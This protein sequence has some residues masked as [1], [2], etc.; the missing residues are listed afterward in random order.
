[1]DI[2]TPIIK[3]LYNEANAQKEAKLAN[4]ANIALEDLKQI[5]EK[6]TINLS[7]PSP[8]SETLNSD[9]KKSTPQ[10]NGTVTNEYLGDKYYDCYKLGCNNSMP[11]KIQQAS[12]D[13][14]QKLSAHGLLVGDEAWE[15]PTISQNLEPILFLKH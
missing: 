8:P 4:L 15:L 11:L 1:M 13:A 12:L 3:R 7:L 9:T 6:N 14:I 10:I 2:V 5:Q